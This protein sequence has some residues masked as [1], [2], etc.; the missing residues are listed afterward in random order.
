MKER[1]G[2]VNIRASHVCDNIASQPRNEQ[3]KQVKGTTTE[4]GKSP[5]KEGEKNK[6]VIAWSKRRKMNVVPRRKINGIP[7]KNIEETSRIFLFFYESSLETDRFF[8][9]ESS[10]RAVGRIKKEILTY[11]WS[12][13]RPNKSKNQSS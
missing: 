1:G 7:N 12:S 13:L 6:E 5:F 9:Y 4:E 3:S 11:L 10:W 8:F 2:I